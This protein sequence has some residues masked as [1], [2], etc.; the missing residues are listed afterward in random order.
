M[1]TA[2]SFNTSID[3][4]TALRTAYAELEY[5]LGGPPSWMAVHGTYQHSGEDIVTILETLAPGVPFQGGTSCRGVMT[6][7]GFHSDQGVGLGLFGIYDPEG[8]YSVGC[9]EGQEFSRRTG[10]AAITQALN[11][12]SRPTAPALIWITCAPGDEEGLIAGIE[13]GLNGVK[14]PIIGGSSADNHTEGQWYQITNG[15]VLYNGVVVTAMYPSRP[16]SY[17]FDNSYQPTILSGVITRISGRTVYEIDHRPAAEVYNEWTDGLIDDYLDGGNI[18]ALST[19]QPLGR[20]AVMTRSTDFYQISHPEA[21]VEDRALTLF[22]T[23]EYGER[24][25]LME[26]T[27]QDVV[28]SAGKIAAKTLSSKIMRSA[29]I[30]GALIIFCAGCMLTVQDDMQVV[31]AQFREALGGQPFLGWH[32]FGEQGCPL[33]GENS[34]A[35][36]MISM[37]VFEG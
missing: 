36:L 5:K 8:V 21:V 16:V 12:Q 18:L 19:L 24:I 7:E 27:P 25:F 17:A 22:T 32:T 1:K 29:D 10:Q 28:Y 30:A 23:A 11:I 15:E 13:L 33:L 3:T 35:N 26:S 31:A 34:H 2:S 37:I 6:E 9:S 20:R 14:V 4:E